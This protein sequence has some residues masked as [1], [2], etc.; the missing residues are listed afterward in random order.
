LPSTGQP[1]VPRWSLIFNRQDNIKSRLLSPTKLLCQNTM[2]GIFYVS[3]QHQGRCSRYSRISPGTSLKCVSCTEQNVELLHRN[4]PA[5]ALAT[6][7][8]LLF[9]TFTSLI[10]SA[11]A[12]HHENGVSNPLLDSNR[13]KLMLSRVSAPRIQDCSSSFL[14][15]AQ[16]TL[17]GF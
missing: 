2:G 14:K 1:S 4:C 6:C 3:I 8:E 13:L 10:C 15:L 11:Y 7:W 5:R 9:A 17:N 12:I 16:A